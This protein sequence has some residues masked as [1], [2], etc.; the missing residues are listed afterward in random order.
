VCVK[1]KNRNEKIG[2]PEKLLKFTKI[3]FTKRKNNAE[4]ILP[5]QWTFEGL[6]TI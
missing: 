3:V 5:Q 1:L 4:R 2:G 6:S